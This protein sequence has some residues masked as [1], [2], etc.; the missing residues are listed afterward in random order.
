MGNTLLGV[1]RM[2]P[3]PVGMQAPKREGAEVHAPAAVRDLGQADRF[4]AQGIGEKALAAL[5]LDAAV[6]ADPPDGEPDGVLG[7]GEAGGK[8]GAARGRTRSSGGVG[9]RQ[10]R[11]PS[12]A[13]PETSLGCG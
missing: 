12:E 10:E 4:A 11:D 8:G 3:V 9:C 6:G 13:G 5:P 2:Q 7:R 1:D